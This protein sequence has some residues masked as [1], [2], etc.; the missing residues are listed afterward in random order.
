M[1][2]KELVKIARERGKITDISEAFKKYPVEDEAHKGE[3]SY[4]LI[5]EKKL[6]V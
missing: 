1:Q 3:L 2:M 5:G 4:W 6:E